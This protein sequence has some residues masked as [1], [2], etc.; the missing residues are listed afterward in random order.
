M[1]ASI[2]HE[3][4]GITTSMGTAKL[5]VD[6]LLNRTFALRA[7][8]KR[9]PHPD[10]IV[11]RC[12]DVSFAQLEKFAAWRAAKLQTRCV[13]GPCQGRICGAAIEFL[14][15]WQP[16]SVRPPVYPVNVGHLIHSASNGNH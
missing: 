10:T 16:E 9:L 2:G 7:E 12:E 8:L 11:C 5:L 14:L 13:T 15:G 1:S 3:G 4:L 6:Q